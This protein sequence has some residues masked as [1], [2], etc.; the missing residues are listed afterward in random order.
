MTSNPVIQEARAI[1]LQR[2][3]YLLLHLGYLA[4]TSLMMILVWPGRDLMYFFRTQ[5]PPPV[6]DVMVVYLMIASCT[7]SV[8]IGLDR[9]SSEAIIRYAEWVE[10]TRVPVSVVASGKLIVAGVHTFVLVSLGI[11]FLVFAAAPAGVGV[12]TVASAVMLILVAALVSRIAGMVISH[13][14]ETSYVMRV[15][16]GWIFVALLFVATI[17]P[18][19]WANPVAM[20]ARLQHTDAVALGMT[21]VG[22][23]ALLHLGMAILL[24]IAFVISLVRHR[25]KAENHGG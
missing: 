6:Y 14:G 2:R 9:L 12:A 25:K 13:W 11:P 22:R 15:V 24:S 20:V 17:E 10:R 23:P 4:F 8:Y 1:Y 21:D 7:L 16:G 5:N 19:P 18:F 3:E